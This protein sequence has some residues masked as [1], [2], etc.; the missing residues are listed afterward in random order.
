[1]GMN[2]NRIAMATVAISVALAAIAG[3][4]VAPVYVVDPFMWLARSSP[5]SPSWC[6]VGWAASRQPDRCADHRLCRGDHRLR[7]A[8]SAYLKGRSRSSSW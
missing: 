6:L 3:V 8:G 7:G 4:V 5:C 2:V 1:M